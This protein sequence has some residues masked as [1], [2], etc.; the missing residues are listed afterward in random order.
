MNKYEEL[1][2]ILMDKLEEKELH[3]NIIVGST[4]NVKWDDIVTPE[5]V[6]FGVINPSGGGNVELNNGALVTTEN[7]TLAIALPNEDYK[8][9]SEAWEK[10]SNAINDIVRVEHEINGDYYIIVNNGKSGTDF[11]TIRGGNQIA[12]MSQSLSLVGGDGLLNTKNVTISITAKSQVGQENST[13]LFKGFYN[14]IFQKQKQFDSIVKQ[15]QLTQENYAN[16]LQ[17]TLTI[18]Y[19]KFSNNTLHRLLE[20]DTETFII[21]LNDGDTTLLNNVEMHLTSLTQNG[22]IGNYINMRV[23]FIDGVV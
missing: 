3:S 18:D 16:S 15:S 23:S 8:K 6:C 20:S 13:H 22:V 2:N 4:I 1:A 10:F 5:F 9:Y 7:I 21:S 12:V 11:L 17:K 14:Y 19:Y